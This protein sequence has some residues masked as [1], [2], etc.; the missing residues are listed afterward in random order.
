MP[1]ADF[2]ERAYSWRG[3]RVILRNLGEDGE[4]F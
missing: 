3:K 1:A 4:E 2:S